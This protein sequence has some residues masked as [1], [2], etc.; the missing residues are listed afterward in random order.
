MCGHGR[1]SGV[2]PLPHDV[3]HTGLWYTVVA[4]RDDMKTRDEQ[5]MRMALQL[6]AKARGR[7]SPN[8]MVG[9]LVV[10]DDKVIAVGYHRRAGEPHAEAI[11]LTQT[12]VLLPA[13]RSWFRAA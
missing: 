13:H 5:Y 1:C 4:F 2:H 10:K 6:A 3:I 9:A 12:N 7:T 11:A 8:P